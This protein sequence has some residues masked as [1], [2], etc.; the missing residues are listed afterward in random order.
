MSDKINAMVAEKIFGWK[1]IHDEYSR[2]WSIPESDPAYADLDGHD[3]TPPYSSDISAA[4]AVVHRV[5]DL[6]SESR[7]GM[8]DVVITF[9]PYTARWTVKFNWSNNK[10]VEWDN[11]SECMAICIAALKAVGVPDSEIQEAL[12]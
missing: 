11:P 2:W 12:Q 5:K 7:G 9:N 1:R 4:W 10:P 8:G 6:H 3:Y